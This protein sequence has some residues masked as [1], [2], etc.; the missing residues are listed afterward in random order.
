MLTL[1][2]LLLPTLL[3]T[4]NDD[5]SSL[6]LMAISPPKFTDSEN[7]NLVKRIIICVGFS[8]II[9]LTIVPSSKKENNAYHM[10]ILNAIGFYIGFYE[11]I[12]SYFID[13]TS[14]I[15]AVPALVIGAVL[16]LYQ[17]TKKIIGTLAVTYPV[18]ILT[19]C[20]VNPQDK[21]IGL[22]IM[23]LE[24]VIIYFLLSG[25]DL[26]FEFS[27]RVIIHTFL[28]CSMLEIT[29]WA[30]FTKCLTLNLLSFGIFELLSRFSIIFIAICY[31][32]AGTVISFLSNT[33]FGGKSE[34]QSKEEKKEEKV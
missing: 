34:E 20:F 27:T 6:S 7:L 8:L 3:C 5:Q 23:I 24:C 17:P 31:F 9:L 11:I 26:V 28:T 1:L 4:S 29:I 2:L 18:Y 32:F 15:Y 13:M 14:A 21:I 30:I 22:I 19:I 16:S 33:L 25:V 10:A 12:M